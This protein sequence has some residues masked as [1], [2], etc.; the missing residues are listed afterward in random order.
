M[1]CLQPQPPTPQQY[2]GNQIGT[3]ATQEMNNELEYNKMPAL[4]PTLLRQHQADEYALTRMLITFSFTIS[5][6]TGSTMRILNKG[7]VLHRQDYRKW[8]EWCIA[9]NKTV[10]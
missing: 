2:P 4:A 8:K 3:A 10:Y 5:K 1:E 6:H 9:H 7:N